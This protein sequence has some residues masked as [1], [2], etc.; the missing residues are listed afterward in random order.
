MIDV[1]EI[2]HCD[3]CD[4]DQGEFDAETGNHPICAEITALQA[5]VELLEAA[6]GKNETIKVFASEMVAKIHENDE[7]GVHFGHWSVD[8]P[9]LRCCD[10]RALLFPPP[11]P[12][13]QSEPP[14]PTPSRYAAEMIAKVDAEKSDERSG[15]R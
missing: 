15:K 6:L 3:F 2:C 10:A 1:N 12:A 14:T 5:R 7:N 9:A 4:G 13:P 11:A 8:C